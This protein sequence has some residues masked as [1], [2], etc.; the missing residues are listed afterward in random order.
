MDYSYYYCWHL[1]LFLLYDVQLNIH[2]YLRKW[3]SQADNVYNKPLHGCFN[4]LPEDSP[5]RTGKQDYNYDIA[6]NTGLLLNDITCYDFA[7]SIQPLPKIKREDMIYHTYWRAD[8]APVGSKQLAT[9][10][11]FFATQHIKTSRVYLWSNSDISESPV[12]KQIKKQVGD[13]LQLLIYDPKSLSKGT[14]MEDSSYFDATDVSEYYLDGNLIQLLALYKYGGLW[15]DMDSLFIRDMTP[16]FER[17]WL[18]QWDCLLPD[19]FPFNGAFM[20]FRKQSPYLCEMLTEMAKGFL[21][22]DN[23]MEWGNYLYYRIYRRLLQNGVRPFSILPWCFVDSLAC[24]PSIPKTD[25]SKDR[26]LDT[27]A[28]RWKK[29]PD[30]F[31]NFLENR[32]KNVTGW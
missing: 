23:T 32:H 3:I 9:L 15:F 31:F 13:R 30:H 20:R 8:H 27:F 22:H 12:I 25:F 1:V 28:Y 11:S 5:Y 6:P 29:G 2:V 7:S 24:A 16:L 18:V 19:G 21:P 26:L 10:R 14:P 4:N 17:E